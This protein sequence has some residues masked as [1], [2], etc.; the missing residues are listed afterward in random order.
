MKGTFFP[1]V[2]IAAVSF[3][4]FL[5][6]I[7]YLA[8]T[9]QSSVFFDLV[10]VLPYGDKIGHFVLFGT[11]TVLASIALKAKYLLIAK[12]IK[13]YW[14]ALAVFAFALGE[15]ISQAFV[16]T[17]TFDLIDLSADILG[18]CVASWLVSKLVFWHKKSQH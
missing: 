15:E 12:K 6:W 8:N 3:F 18:I 2:A 9:S 7:I 14:G 17:R 4:G 1:L 13:L 5:L 11:L 10:K 16:A